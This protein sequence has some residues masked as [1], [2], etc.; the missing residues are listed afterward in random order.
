M[1]NYPVLRMNKILL[2]KFKLLLFF[3][4]AFTFIQAQNMIIKGSVIDLTD[5]E[6]LIG[7]TIYLPETGDATFTDVNG[8][9]EIKSTKAIT[10]IKASFV[11]YK[12]TLIK[13]NPQKSIHSIRIAL[14]RNIKALNEVEIV[15]DANSANEKINKV[16]MGVDKISMIEAKLLPAI[17]GE[18]DIIKILQLKPGVKSGGEGTAG[19]F[20]RGGSSDQNLILVERAPVYNPNHLLGFFSVFNSDAVTNVTLYKSGFPSQFG[21]RLSSVLDV[22]MNKGQADSMVLQGGIGL[23]ASRLS[24]NIPIVK[25]K[26]SLFVATRRTYL[27]VLTNALN[28]VN[29]DKEDYEIIPAYFFYDFNTSLKYNINQKNKLSLTGYFGNDIFKFNQGSFNA[30]LLWGNRS[31]TLDWNHTFNGRLKSSTA[32]FTSGYL[33]RINTGFSRASVSLGSRIW[34]QA[35]LS[36]WTYYLHAKHV[37]KFGVSAI[38]H[39]FTVGEFGFS[40][41]FNDLESGKQ[42][43]AGEMGAYVSH[44]WKASNKLDV[45][46]G[47]RHSTFVSKNKTYNGLEPR[48]AL[49]YSILSNTTIKASYAKMYQ[50]LHLVT[51]S[52]ATLPTDIWYPSEEGVKPQSSDQLSLGLHQA[53]AKSVYFVSLEGYYKWIHNA[54]D[55]RDG[56]QLFANTNLNREF[57][58]GKGWAYGI[59]SYIEK[60]KGKT[61]GWIGYTLS[62]TWR[63]FKE[64]NYGLAFHPRYDRRH[65]FSFVVMHQLNS[66][67]SLSATWIY[68]TG[69]YATIA[70]GRFVSQEALESQVSITP[71]YVN[72]NDFQMPATHRLDLGLVWKLKSKRGQTDLTFSLYNAYSRRNP[73]FIYYKEEL[74]ANKNVVAYQPTLVS[75]FP[76]LPAITYNFKF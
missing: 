75:L 40:S 20:V 11:G 10:L 48:V 38:Y 8:N 29:K 25:E 35:L 15:V 24:L 51:S 52:G 18:V 53:I 76:I 31:L 28:E 37:L 39:R 12:D 2:R 54:I 27:D 19:F 34:D 46:S 71:D 6:K 4:L 69:N 36:D 50:Y 63:Q 57:V 58:F 59:E 17:F 9:F 55:F 65:D 64:I 66:K 16:E 3:I 42:I 62:W 67:I 72:R 23:L 70:G 49:K 5:K 47:L 26:L 33:Y 14:V 13:I 68:G 61:T 30:K 1:F 73:Y 32:F 44:A 56:A 7:A 22:E 21:G 43:E 60:K 45:L 41:D 74:D